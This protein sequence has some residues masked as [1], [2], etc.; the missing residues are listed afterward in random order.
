MAILLHARL[1]NTALL[2]FLFMAVWGFWRFFRQQGLGSSYWGA[3]LIA[4]VLI[5]FQGGLGLYLW[6]TDSPPARGGIHVLYGV[7]LALA[8]PLVYSYTRGRQDRAE[9]LLYAVAFLIMCGLVLRAMV[10]GS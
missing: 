7:A 2:F 1:A 3:A 5:L 6:I 8:V 9:M 10:T 4:E